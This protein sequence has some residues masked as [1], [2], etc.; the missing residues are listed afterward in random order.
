MLLHI[1]EITLRLIPQDS[2]LDT[3]GRENHKPHFRCRVDK[4]PGED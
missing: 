3:R 2:H 4:I 1:Q